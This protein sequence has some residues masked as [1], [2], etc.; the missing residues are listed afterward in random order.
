MKIVYFAED[1]TQFD[2]EKDCIAYENAKVIYC[3]KKT[4]NEYE[5]RITRICSTLEEAEKEL[6]NC[7]DWYN[8]KGTGQIYKVKIDTNLE[9]KYELAVD[10]S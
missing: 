3:I 7:C 2:N 5:R 10:K 8:S 6:K 4:V 1:G 9:P